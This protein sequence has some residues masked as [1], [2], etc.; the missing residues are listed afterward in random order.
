MEK[1]EAYA[2][3]LEGEMA[4]LESEFK[5]IPE[6][7]RVLE[8]K[9]LD[10]IPAM[11]STAPKKINKNG[12]VSKV[13]EKWEQ[14]RNDFVAKGI[15]KFAQTKVKDKKTGEVTKIR[16]VPKPF[17]IDS[18]HDLRPLFFEHLGYEPKEWTRNDKDPTFVP[19]IKVDKKTLPYIGPGGVVLHSYRLVRDEHKFIRA[20]L[21]LQRDGTFH[22]KVKSIATVTGR[23][24]G[25]SEEV[26]GKKY[27]LNIQQL[28]KREG[29]LE[30]FVARP[31]H[32]LI[33]TDFTS[34]EMKVAAIASR[35]ENLYKLYGPLANHNHDVYLFN[36]AQIPQYSAGIKEL[37]DL[38]N[39]TA[40]GVKA[41]KTKFGKT[42][43]DI[44]KPWV[45]GCQYGLGGYTLF[46]NLKL[47]KVEVTLDFC[48]DLIRVF[49]ET[50]PG[51]GRLQRKSRARWRSSRKGRTNGWFTS[52]RGRPMCVDIDKLKDINNRNFQSSGHDF[53]QLYLQF[54]V[55]RIK[56]KARPYMVDTHDSTIWE[57][58]D[59]NIPYV[60]T[61]FELAYDDLNEALGFDIK[62]DGDIKLGDSLAD[63]LLED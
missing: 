55:R 48:F 49:R 35:D 27:R 62:F 5:G 54:L 31:R 25:G 9:Y 12:S 8:R 59:K 43:Q 56:D 13:W 30:C 32:R 42:R 41:A 24:G 34:L 61:M 19:Q 26:D 52:L 10:N 44:F 2:L 38:D 50:Y 63:V 14:R 4:E 20:A 39:P 11:D 16:L 46:E 22:P 40:E 23:L 33:Y 21:Y 53:L 6:V 36:G 37:Y 57:V 28:P 1:A 45:L 60:Q 47:A 58:A 3:K 17:N 18:I 51:L 15:W 29:F 7:S